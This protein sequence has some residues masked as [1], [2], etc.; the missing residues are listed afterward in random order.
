VSPSQVS[1]IIPCY[2][3]GSYIAEAIGSVLAQAAAPLQVIVVDDGSTD[4]SS[5]VLRS[6]GNKIEYYR[7]ENAGISAA[8]NAGLAHAHG[9]FLAFLDADD[10]WP[11][12]SLGSRLAVLA[13]DGGV[14]CVFGAV[15]QFISHDIAASRAA[16]LRVDAAPVPCRLAGSMLIRR[17]A[18][19]RVGLFNTA[20]KVGETI[21]WVARA[22][23]GQLSMRSVQDVVLMRRVHNS[24]TVLRET[25]HRGDY[26]RALKSGLDRRRAAEF[27]GAT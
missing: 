12:G 10:I 11:V 2:N 19:A 6:F 25:K 24:N 20:L 8:R 23:T 13:A 5:V 1:V 14:E 17:A 27:R 15:Q 4:D 3:A 16:F 18:F 7:Q 21:E 9:A 22:E 26:L